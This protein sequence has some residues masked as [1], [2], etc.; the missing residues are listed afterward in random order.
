MN[1]KA[2]GY[3]RQAGSAQAGQPVIT[4]HEWDAAV[5][6]AGDQILIARLLAGHRLIPEQCLLQ[7][8]DMAIV[9]LDVCIGATANKLFT[10]VAVT[11][12]GT[13]TKAN[14]AT[15]AAI[16]AFGVSDEDRDV[17]I[18]IN[19]GAATAP[20]GSKAILTF[21]QAPSTD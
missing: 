17:F 18:L 7:L 13:Y 5:Q 10:G 19:S 12:A 8:V 4:R 14:G 9:N 11:V 1:S 20:A 16:D 3:S 15:T 2:R 21:A 6:T